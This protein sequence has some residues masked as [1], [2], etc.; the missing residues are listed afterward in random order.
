MPQNKV[1]TQSSFLLFK[2][3]KYIPKPRIEGTQMPI[4]MAASDSPLKYSIS[5]K[6]SE[7]KAEINN[8]LSVIEKFFNMIELILKSCVQL[9]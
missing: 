9:V 4:K 5:E 3:F 2:I 8:S 6:M 7:R 1:S